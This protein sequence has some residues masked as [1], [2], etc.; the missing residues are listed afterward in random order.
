MPLDKLQ[1]RPVPG[2]EKLRR[3]VPSIRSGAHTVE[4]PTAAQFWYRSVTA[5][6]PPAQAPLLSSQES[7]GVEEERTDADDTSARGAAV[8]GTAAGEDT[9]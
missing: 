2:N 4:G 6:A 9:A 5:V 1:V 3:D 8:G 7:V